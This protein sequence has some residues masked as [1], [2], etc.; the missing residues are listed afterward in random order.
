M[1]FE[2][3]NTVAFSSDYFRLSPEE[4]KF[5]KDKGY[6]EDQVV[7]LLKNKDLKEFKKDARGA[8]IDVAGADQT[9]DEYMKSEDRGFFEKAIYGVAE[10]APAM[11][12]GFGGGTASF[13]GLAAQ[14][15]SSIE[16]EMLND[17]DFETS[18]A[19]ERAVVAVPY[20]VLMGVLENYGLKNTM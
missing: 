20:A 5:Y 19:E 7:N 14:S 15:Y 13:A 12:L 16:D 17:P 4:K 10:S 9:T 2:L 8:L 3:A 1:P 18:T 6:T 11:L